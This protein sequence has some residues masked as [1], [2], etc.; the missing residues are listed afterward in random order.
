MSR[1]QEIAQDKALCEKISLAILETESTARGSG[2]ESAD[3][4]CTL[5]YSLALI[6]KLSCICI[7]V[8]VHMYIA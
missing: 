1:A 4:S 8:Y 7:C 3:K 5:I 2:M 6:L